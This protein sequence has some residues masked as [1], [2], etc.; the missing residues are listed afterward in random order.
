MDALYLHKNLSPTGGKPHQAQSEAMHKEK[1]SLHRGKLLTDAAPSL[2]QDKPSSHGESS[3]QNRK[4]APLRP[5]IQGKAII[6]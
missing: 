5:P 2:G 4:S 6:S 1:L 3:R